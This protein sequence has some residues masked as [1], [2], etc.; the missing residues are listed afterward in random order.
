MVALNAAFQLGVVSGRVE[1]YDVPKWSGI[2]VLSTRFVWR[3]RRAG[4]ANDM[5]PE[6]RSGDRVRAVK[7]VL[8]KGEREIGGAFWITGDGKKGDKLPLSDLFERR[9]GGTEGQ[10]F[11]D[12]R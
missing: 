9:N 10:R 12:G 3:S 1:D 4:R 5:S 6:R 11:P 7:S 2:P 8:A